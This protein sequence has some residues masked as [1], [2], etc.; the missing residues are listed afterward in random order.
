MALSMYEYWLM[1]KIVW[2]P[3]LLASRW[4]HIEAKRC[5]LGG[6]PRGCKLR[7]CISLFCSSCFTSFQ[8]F[9]GRE[10]QPSLASTDFLRWPS[11]LRKDQTQV[12][13][14]YTF[15]RSTLSIQERHIYVA[16]SGII[17][18]SK[19][20]Y[21]AQIRL[22]SGSSSLRQSQAL[23]PSYSRSCVQQQQQQQQAAARLLFALAHGELF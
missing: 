13:G 16:G 7:H 5:G 12:G 2:V 10:R 21:H 11:V 17:S 4:A 6:T 8:F 9:F 18:K 15:R 22:R 19:L 1:K 3:Q 20:S 23:Q 14:D